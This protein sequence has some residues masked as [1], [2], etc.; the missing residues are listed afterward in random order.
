M[1]ADG[2]LKLIVRETNRNACHELGIEEGGADDA[3]WTDP[4]E[5]RRNLGLVNTM[6][7]S[8]AK[9]PSLLVAK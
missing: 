9:R 5:I 1:V 7:L 2:I 8:T 6:G 3:P 4:E